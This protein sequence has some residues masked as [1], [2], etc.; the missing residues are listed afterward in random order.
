MSGEGQR[1]KEREKISS[2]LRAVSTVHRVGLKP[3]NCEI[4]TWA[5]TKSQLLNWLNHPGA[6]HLRF[7]KDVLHCFLELA[8]PVS[9][10]HWLFS[11][12][13]KWKWIQRCHHWWVSPWDWVSEVGQLSDDYWRW[14]KFSL[15]SGKSPS[16]I[17]V[18]FLGTEWQW[19]FSLQL[20]YIYQEFHS[21]PSTLLLLS[22]RVTEKFWRNSEFI[23]SW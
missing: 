13:R 3:T 4:M 2:R 16:A 11:R 9:D 7:L 19:H 18:G 6:P 17:R 20:W 8:I 15:P 14:G 23:D 12:K 5:K 22:P 1:E 21:L 10:F